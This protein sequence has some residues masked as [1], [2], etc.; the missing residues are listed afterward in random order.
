[1]G[2]GAG[3]KCAIIVSVFHQIFPPSLSRINATKKH[4][5]AHVFFAGYRLVCLGV[6]VFP[7]FFLLSPSFCYGLD[8]PLLF[9][10]FPSMLLNFVRHS[11]SLPP[12]RLCPSFSFLLRLVHAS[13]PMFLLCFCVKT[14]SA[15]TFRRRL[16]QNSHKGTV[17]LHY[18]QLIFYF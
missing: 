11:K 12:S 8:L 5:H 17:C 9:V 18:F 1:M 3:D 6:S 7:S 2:G 13:K 4:K 14:C 15:F 16:L 10:K